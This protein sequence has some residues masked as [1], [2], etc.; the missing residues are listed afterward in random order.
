MGLQNRAPGVT[1]EA[2]EEPGFNGV[3]FTPE[4]ARS[5]VVILYFHGGA[6]R[7]GSV[8]SWGPYMSRLAAITK[9]EVLGVEYA[10]APESPYP[11]AANEAKAAFDWLADQGLKVVLGGDSAGCNLAAGLALR[12]EPATDRLHVGTM[13]F[14]PWIDFTVKNASYSE[15]ADTDELFSREAAEEAVGF[16]APGL[17]AAD[18]AISP[19]LGSWDAQ[20]PVLVETSRDEVLRDDARALAQS[21]LAAG[22]QVWFREVPGQPHDWHINDPVVGATHDS[23]ALAAAFIDSLHSEQE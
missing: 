19:G 8:K 18:P 1:E 2:V 10:L 20:P 21:L 5:G 12:V 4:G 3:R 15:C 7:M 17:D 14:S 22:V 11:A 6:L 9:T 16:Y 23:L 13:L